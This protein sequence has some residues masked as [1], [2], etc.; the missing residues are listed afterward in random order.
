VNQIQGH[1][2]FYIST[3]LFIANNCIISQQYGV[4]VKWL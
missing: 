2:Y 4:V 3:T 1:L